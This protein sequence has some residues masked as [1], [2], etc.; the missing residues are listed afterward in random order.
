MHKSF[1]ILLITIS[2]VRL[3]YLAMR[4]RFGLQSFS[5]DVADNVSHPRRLDPTM[6][7]ITYSFVLYLQHSRHDV[8]R[9]P[10][11]GRLLII[12]KIHCLHRQ[13]DDKK[14][15]TETLVKFPDHIFI[16]FAAVSLDELRDLNLGLRFGRSKC[17]LYFDSCITN[18]KRLKEIL[19]L[20]IYGIELLI[21]E[22]TKI[23]NRPQEQDK[24]ISP[25]CPPAVHLLNFC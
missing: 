11:V 15:K 24:K 9:K 8:K 10:S 20:D 18:K 6:E 5:R 1:D 2:T 19:L 21:N 13:K 23:T 17:L 3:S 25:S 12:P 16:D 22:P 14:I 4:S 7:L